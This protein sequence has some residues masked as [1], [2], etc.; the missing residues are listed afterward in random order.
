LQSVLALAPAADL[1]MAHALNLG[2]G[3]D[4]RFLGEDPL[5]RLDVNPMR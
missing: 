1:Q 5:N 4:H 3:A 2:N